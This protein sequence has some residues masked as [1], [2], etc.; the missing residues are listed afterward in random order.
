MAIRIGVIDAIIREKGTEALKVAKELGFEGVEFF[1]PAPWDDDTWQSADF[2]QEV[3]GTAEGLGMGIPSLALAYMNG[4]PLASP[5]PIVQWAVLQSLLGYIEA[6]EAVGAGQLLLAFYGPGE[7]A[8]RR[9]MGVLVQQ[10][11][12][13][14]PAAKAAGVKLGIESTLTSGQYLRILEEVGSPAV[15]IYLDM[16][17]PYDWCHD[18]G[19]QIRSLGRHI[20]QIH[21]KDAGPQGGTDLGDG[22]NDWDDIAAALKEIGYDGWAVLETPSLHG[23]PRKDAQMN[24][25]RAREIAARCA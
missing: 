13:A 24:L 25:E 5:D 12:A 3:R 14:A 19:E 20:G 7:L 8:F 21:F 6:A 9:Q 16:R 15:N 2:R 17:N 18:T 11:K 1:V 22:T 10:L 23:D 4:C